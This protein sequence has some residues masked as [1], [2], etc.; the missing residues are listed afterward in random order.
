MQALVKKYSAP[1]VESKF[2]AREATLDR[3]ISRQLEK[4]IKIEQLL[5]SARDQFPELADQIER[6]VH[7]QSTTSRSN[8]NWSPNSNRGISSNNSN[9][10][11][12]S[13]RGPNSNNN[14]NHHLYKLA[15]GVP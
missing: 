10:G 6:A 3:E 11:P 14:L 8:P 15:D 2:E 9:R 13:S 4:A 12:S 1:D 5:N 7:G